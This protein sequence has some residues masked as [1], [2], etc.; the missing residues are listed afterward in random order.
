MS[1]IF[2][3]ITKAQREYLELRIANSG[4]NQS[5][6]VRSIFNLWV[7]L[8]APALTDLETFKPLPPIPHE[9]GINLPQVC[10]HLQLYWDQVFE[11]HTFGPMPDGPI[12]S[13]PA[14][15]VLARQDKRRAEL[16]RGTSAVP[17]RA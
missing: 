16:A 3:Q 4:S 8:G 9:A 14:R 10:S 13:S 7:Y 17:K 6:A 15:R 12:P 1:Q 11:A 2:G 5:V